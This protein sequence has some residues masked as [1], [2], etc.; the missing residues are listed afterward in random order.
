[1]TFTILARDP[2]GEYLAAATASRSLG[3]GANVLALDPA[4]GAVASQAWT[5]PLLRHRALA[6]MRAGQVPGEVIDRLPEWDEGVARRQVALLGLRGRGSA[7][8]GPECTPHTAQRVGDGYVVLGNVLSARAV[9]DDIVTAL[10]LP[11]Q[12]RASPDRS[13]GEREA[14]HACDV[15]RHVLRAM[16]A[17][18]AAGGD[19][20]GRQSAA[21]QVARV[22]QVSLWPPQL[23]L[24]LR[25]DDHDEPLAELERLLGLRD[26]A[27]QASNGVTAPSTTVSS[28]ASLAHQCGVEQ[29]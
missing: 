18:E 26:A 6:A 3:V 13:R 22:Q 7:W 29:V 8:T 11:T 2:R 27:L 20:R 24:D 9:V 28:E 14:L 10:E 25:V 4:V 1:M 5:N 21:I 19:S 15:G 17:G 16:H 12:G 23:A